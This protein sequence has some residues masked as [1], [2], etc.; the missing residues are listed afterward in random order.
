[1][2]FL[3]GRIAREMTVSTVPMLPLNADSVMLLIIEY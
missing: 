2:C 1:M 3:A